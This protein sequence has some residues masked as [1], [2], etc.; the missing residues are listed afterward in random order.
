VQDVHYVPNISDLHDP[1][2]KKRQSNCGSSHL[3]YLEKE[4][5]SNPCMILLVPCCRAG[6]IFD[7]SLFLSVCLSVFLPLVLPLCLF[8]FKKE[9]LQKFPKDNY[10]GKY[11]CSLEASIIKYLWSYF[12]GEESLNKETLA[13]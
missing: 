6:S 11:M 13:N 1:C 10:L 2:P 9:L 5:H 8:C 3:A 7:I 12:K 4:P